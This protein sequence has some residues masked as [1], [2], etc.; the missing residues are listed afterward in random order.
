MF[1]LLIDSQ[2]YLFIIRFDFRRPRGFRIEDFA[3]GALINTI[4][5]NLH[6]LLCFASACMYFIVAFGK[7]SFRECSCSCSWISFCRGLTKLHNYSIVSTLSLFNSIFKGIC[8]HLN[9]FVYIALCLF[10]YFVYTL[11]RN[12]FSSRFSNGQF[13]ILH[14]Y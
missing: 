6:H 5:F 7:L 4:I 1:T 10:A 8:Q 14:F 13:Q 2:F 9:D 12:L 11:I 3:N